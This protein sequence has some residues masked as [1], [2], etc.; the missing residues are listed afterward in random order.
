MTAT[1]DD[2]VKIKAQKHS[3]SDSWRPIW[4]TEHA[5]KD[6]CK[7]VMIRCC[8]RDRDPR[9]RRHGS[10]IRH[11]LSHSRLSHN[12]DHTRSD[13]TSARFFPCRV[14]ELSSNLR[15]H[16]TIG[17][18]FFSRYCYLLFAASTKFIAVPFRSADII[19][20]IAQGDAPAQNLDSY[21]YFLLWLIW[22]CDVCTIQIRSPWPQ[23]VSRRSS[24]VEI[25]HCRRPAKVV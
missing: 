21:V 13:V 20:L 15:I 2:S 16:Y 3:A 4:Y 1:V 9:S 19:T 18:I 24:D 7:F 22:K 6:A 14:R 8:C 23:A 10:I 17:W 25:R 5:D 11:S 12:D